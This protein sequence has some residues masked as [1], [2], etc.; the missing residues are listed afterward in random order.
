MSPFFPF[1]A[2]EWVGFVLSCL[3]RGQI[4]REA[5]LGCGPLGVLQKPKL[6]KEIK[7]GLLAGSLQELQRG[8][9]G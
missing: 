5:A 9:V 4:V 8:E 1:L 2:G 6:I 3:G 7:L